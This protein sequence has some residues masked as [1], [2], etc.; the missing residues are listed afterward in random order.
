[1]TDLLDVL[2]ELEAGLASPQ[3]RRYLHDLLTGGDLQGQPAA[4]DVHTQGCS[5]ANTAAIKVH[6]R[7]QPPCHPKPVKPAHRQAQ[8]GTS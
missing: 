4:G 6:S 7:Q 3:R 2:H 8:R 1:M 5:G